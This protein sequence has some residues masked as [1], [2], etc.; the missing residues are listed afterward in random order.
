MEKIAFTGLFFKEN[1]M[2]VGYCPELD[3]SSCGKGVEEAKENLLEAVR[4]F[5]EE[6]EKMG[7]LEEILEEA[8]F[9]SPDKRGQE[10]IPPALVCTERMELEVGGGS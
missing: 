4:L 1:G 5:L 10:W 3:V 8:G 2:Y 7:T 6:T 9:T